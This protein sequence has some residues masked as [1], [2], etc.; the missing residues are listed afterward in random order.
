MEPHVWTLAVWDVAR[1][2][3]AALA[4]SG[5]EARIRGLHWQLV[6]LVMVFAEVVEVVRD[7]DDAVVAGLSML[8][9][10]H[11]TAV[12]QSYFDLASLVSLDRIE[13]GNAPK[14]N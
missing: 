5:D 12:F 3:W 4:T 7:D 6:N 11:P 14:V 9:K 2:E 13:R 10:V 8:P 1:R